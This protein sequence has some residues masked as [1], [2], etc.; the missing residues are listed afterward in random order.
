MAGPSN[1][2]NYIGTLLLDSQN[3]DKTLLSEDSDSLP[4][5][6]LRYVEQQLPAYS[7]RDQAS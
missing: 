6:S 5:D 3:E 2:D 7:E 1:S 4:N